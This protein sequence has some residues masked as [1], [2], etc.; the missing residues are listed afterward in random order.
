M[1]FSAKLLASKT[2]ICARAGIISNGDEI[3]TIPAM[4]SERRARGDGVLICLRRCRGER[5]RR[6]A[7]PQLEQT[8]AAPGLAIIIP[9]RHGTRQNFDLA[10]IEAEAAIDRHDLRLEGAFIGEKYPRRAAFHD[11]RRDGAAFDVRE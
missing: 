1:T 11:G 4:S 3:T 8:V 2:A 7:Q 10:I 5:E 6:L 9:P